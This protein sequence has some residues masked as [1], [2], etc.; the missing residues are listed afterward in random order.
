MS[1]NDDT[2][3]WNGLARE[4]RRGRFIRT[5]SGQR[6]WPLDP[7]PREVHVSDVAHHLANLCRFTGAVREPYSVAQHSC[8]VSDL[9]ALKA[10][11]LG[12]SRRE[13]KAL[14]FEALLHDATE[15]YLNDVS[16]PVKVQ[17]ELAG[18]RAAEERVRLAVA[19]RFGLPREE[20]P[21]VKWADRLALVMEA[22]DLMPPSDDFADRGSPAPRKV[23]PWGHRRARW[24][25][26]QRFGAL[27]D[28]LATREPEEI[29]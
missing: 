19:E 8:L 7:R 28:A 26:L 23:E 1:V 18:Y 3:T 22:R 12:L 10:R 24:E 16:T 9:V 20:T 17:P 6:F 15:A 27:S 25:F 2:A 14:A 5:A 11:S 13:V 29:R 21:I 4:V